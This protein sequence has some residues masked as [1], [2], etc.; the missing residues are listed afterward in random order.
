MLLPPMSLSIRSFGIEPLRED[1]KMGTPS[2]SSEEEGS[3]IMRDER[4]KGV[5][6]ER[7]TPRAF[8]HGLIYSAFNR[9][10]PPI[11]IYIS[12]QNV[13]F[14]TS[15]AR[16]TQSLLCKRRWPFAT[17]SN[18]WFGLGSWSLSLSRS[19]IFILN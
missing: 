5:D 10:N 3:T 6:R 18:A 1:G 19:L 12:F 2:D 8:K 14:P 15:A 13:F 7:R 16:Q 17:N 4:N 9:L 11:Y